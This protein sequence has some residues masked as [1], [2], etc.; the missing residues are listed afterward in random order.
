[1]TLNHMKKSYIVETGSADLK[2]QV[3][4]G[5]GSACVTLILFH[6]IFEMSDEQFT[7]YCGTENNEWMTAIIID[8]TTEVDG[9]GQN[10]HIDLTLSYLYYNH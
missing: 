8:N 7:Q 4:G 5:L 1:M 3:T 2:Y 9:I 10:L 6:K